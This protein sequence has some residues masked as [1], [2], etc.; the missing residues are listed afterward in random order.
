MHAPCRCPASLAAE[1]HI[2]AGRLP[3]CSNTSVNALRHRTCGASRVA[4]SRRLPAEL[5]FPPPPVP[6]A[7]QHQGHAS[8]RGS[9]ALG[10][11]PERRRAHD[12]A[13][14]PGGAL[15]GAGRN[16]RPEGGRGGL[17]R[18]L[19]LGLLSYVLDAGRGCGDLGRLL[20]GAEDCTGARSGRRWVRERPIG[21][22]GQ[23]G[24]R[25]SP[26]SAS[27]LPQAPRRPL[28]QDCEARVAISGPAGAVASSTQPSI[29]GG[30]G[31]RRSAA[32]GVPPPCTLA[33]L[34]AFRCLIS[35]R[36]TCHG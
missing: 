6:G 16:A 33:S 7:H 24:R 9:R 31:G 32:A 27:C 10:G 5:P 23:V 21:T 1:K 8:H 12:G 15:H 18:L 36:H 28:L 2:A 29:P 34:V 14:R 35:A 22:R 19:G 25:I 4:A 30:A 17:H 3:P 11:L 26:R 20:P 13:G